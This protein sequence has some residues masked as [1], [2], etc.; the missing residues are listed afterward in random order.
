[1]VM[2]GSETEKNIQAAFEGESMAR[3]RY[4][5]FEEQAA[6][7]GHEEVAQMFGRMAKNEMNHAKLWYK[8]MNGGINDSLANI[9]DAAKGEGYEWTNMYPQFAK[10]ARAEGFEDI[11]KMFDQVAQIERDHEMSFLKAFAALRNKM[12]NKN[13]E[14]VKPVAEEK[15]KRI[16]R[17]QFCG[18][19]YESRPDFCSVCKAIGAFDEAFE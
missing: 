14:S 4:T 5:Y 2:K 19:V 6:K 7:E 1:M 16:F 8:L 11:A 10:T 17:C 9:Q 3:S 18:A 15:K 12:S 13:E